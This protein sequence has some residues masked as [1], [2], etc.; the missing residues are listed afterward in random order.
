M[1]DDKQPTEDE[2]RKRAL[3]LIEK[4]M[5]E[6]EFEENSRGQCGEKQ[7]PEQ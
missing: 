4:W 2:K 6:L 7:D 5:K 3:R 1:F